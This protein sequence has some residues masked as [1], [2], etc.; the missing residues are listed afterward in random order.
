MRRDKA[1]LQDI[2]SSI[3]AIKKFLK[4]VKAERFQKNREKQF[5]VVRALEIIGEAA[6]QISKEL[7]CKHPQIPWKEVAGM[8]DR[9]IHDYFG[10]DTDIVWDTATKDLPKLEIS[11]T[12]ILEDK[13]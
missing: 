8:R 3:K 6:K 9:L 2:L 13:F 11:I 10:V 5:A 4:G 12:K 1:Y 7:R